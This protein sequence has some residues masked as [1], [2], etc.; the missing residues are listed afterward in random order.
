MHIMKFKNTLKIVNFYSIL[1]VH[2]PWFS[3][4]NLKYSSSRDSPFSNFFQR[5][6]ELTDIEANQNDTESN[7]EDNT[8]SVFLL[9]VEVSTSISLIDAMGSEPEPKSIG[10]EHAEDGTTHTNSGKDTLLDSPFR[11]SF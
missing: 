1:R 5:W 3:V 9:G 10:G 11:G 4:N 7:C 6:W 8:S 2:N